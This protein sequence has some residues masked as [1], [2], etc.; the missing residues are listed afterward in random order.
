MSPAK[1]TPTPNSTAPST[2]TT[3]TRRVRGTARA[4]EPSERRATSYSI[5]EQSGR[6][7]VVPYDV[8]GAPVRLHPLGM[9]LHRSAEE[10]RTAIDRYV[11]HEARIDAMDVG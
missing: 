8:R 11:E 1:P 7:A 3:G 10:A 9:G 6:F 5:V 2:S 4:T